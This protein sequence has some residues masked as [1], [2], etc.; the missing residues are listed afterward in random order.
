MKKILIIAVALSLGGCAQQLAEFKAGL[1]AAQNFS[2]TQGQVDAARATYDGTIL[3]PLNTY[4][5][6][7]RCK[8]GQAVTATNLCHDRVL[9]K[10]I[11]TADNTVANGLDNLQ[12]LVTS[13]NNSGAVA[14]YNS[15]KSAIAIAQSLIAASGVTGIK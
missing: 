12:D 2:I 11:R 5:S 9:L 8:T 1:S 10:K 3:A 14:A 13:G 6:W 15:L 7:P 4:A